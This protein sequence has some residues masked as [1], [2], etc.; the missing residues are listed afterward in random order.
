MAWVRSGGLLLAMV[1]IR[2]RQGEAQRHKKV[3]DGQAM[4]HVGKVGKVK[5]REPVL[6]ELHP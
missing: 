6:L 5:L 4:N 1:V 3:Q 2:E